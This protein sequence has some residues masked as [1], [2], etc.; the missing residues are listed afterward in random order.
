MEHVALKEFIFFSMIGDF[1]K[2]KYYLLYHHEKIIIRKIIEEKSTI[3]NHVTRDFC[4]W[5]KLYY[6]EFS[7]VVISKKYKIK[8]R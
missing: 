3:D 4:K 6:M 1:I 8:S 2:F 7:Y 5:E